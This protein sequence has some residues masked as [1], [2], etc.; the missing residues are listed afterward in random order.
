[1]RTWY[2][3]SWFEK[4]RTSLDDVL[5]EVDENIMSNIMAFAPYNIGDKIGQMVMVKTPVVKV[6]EVNEL[7]ETTR[8]TGGFGSSG[9]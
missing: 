7:S 2:R 3:L 8:G 1:M 4:L 6:T 9:K 5:I